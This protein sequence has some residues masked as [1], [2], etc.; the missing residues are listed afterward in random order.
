MATCSHC[1]QELTA[2]AT[3]CYACGTPV[4]VAG[5]PPPVAT[6]VEKKVEAGTRCAICQTALK[7][8]EP[9][10]ACPACGSV[11]HTDCWEENGGCAVYG[12][13]RVPQVEQRR[14]VE[15]PVSYWGQEN[16]P[17]PACGRE[18]LAAA[19]R[20]RFCGATFSSAQPE[21]TGAFQARSALQQR[22]PK[23]RQLVIWQF[24]LSVVPCT[25]PIGGIWGLIWHPT[26]REEIAALPSLYRAL[27]KIGI[28]VGLGQFAILVLMAIFYSV[29]RA[30]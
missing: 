23:A 1:G 19:V 18:I 25:A 10:T 11:Y 21:D 29:L 12:C 6:I 3:I 16:K 8:D 5:N 22:L 26:H 15:I 2:G 27:S 20:C 7:E 28:V 24:I 9:K 4:S 17:C 14:A 30:H 13:S